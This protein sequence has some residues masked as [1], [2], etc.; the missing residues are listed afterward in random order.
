MSNNMTIFDKI[1][2]AV[3]FAEA[4]EYNTSR[5][6]ISRTASSEPA[7]PETEKKNLFLRTLVFSS[8]SILVYILLFE[9]ED[10][11]TTNYTMGSIY[12]V[13]PVGTAF[14]FA[15]IHGAFASNLLSVLGLAAKK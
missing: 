5:E 11:V 13:F 4:G 6:F 10:W 3:A 12:A 2:F 15:L 1:T 8:I 9:N 14:L 7:T